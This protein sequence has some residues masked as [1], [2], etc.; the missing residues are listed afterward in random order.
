MRRWGIACAS[1]GPF[2]AL[3]VLVDL[4]L[5]DAFDSIA[6]EWARPNNVWGTAQ[7]RADLVVE[8][9]RPAVVAGLLAAFTLAYCVKRRS[10]RPAAFV[11]LVCIA[12]ATLTIALKTSVGRADPHGSVA[13]T[14]GSFPSGHMVS[15]IVCLGLALLISVPRAGAWIWL[16][17]A[18]GGVLMGTSLLL[19]AAHWSTDIVGGALLATSVLAVTTASGYSRWLHNPS[20]ND[21]GF[22]DSGESAASSL[23]P[24]GHERFGE[25]RGIS[26][27]ATWVG[28]D[29]YDPGRGKVS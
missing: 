28:T 13:Y 4:G 25:R 10:F 27:P 21:Q 20:A 2:I 11:G 1:A 12:T 19:Q 9:L 18:T 16:I 8:G 26:Q 3:A 22:S 17:P 23:A 29:C 15:V 24:V 7:L 5:V 6:R 14:G